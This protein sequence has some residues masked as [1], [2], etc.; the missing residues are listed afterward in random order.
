MFSAKKDILESIREESSEENPEKIKEEVTEAQGVRS[1]E[2]PHG[3]KG[4]GTLIPG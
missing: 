3:V 1:R 4:G 2:E